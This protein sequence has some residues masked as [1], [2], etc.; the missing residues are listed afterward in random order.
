[1]AEKVVRELNQFKKK[2]KELTLRLERETKSRKLGERLAT[3]AEKAKQRLT[4]Q[5]KTVREQER[6][7]AAEIKSMV[8]DASKREQALKDARGK[9]AELREGLALK[10]EELKRRSQQLKKLL[11]ESA[12]RAAAIIHGEGESGATAAETQPSTPPAPVESSPQE[13]PTDEPKAT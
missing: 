11:A 7:L 4:S 3:E 2:L 9:V 10:T 12:H 6:K 13:K 1:M 8:A 5:L